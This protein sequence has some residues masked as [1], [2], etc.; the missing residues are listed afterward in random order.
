V[1]LAAEALDLLGQPEREEQADESDQ[2]DQSE[3]AANDR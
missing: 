1:L 3:R 2:T